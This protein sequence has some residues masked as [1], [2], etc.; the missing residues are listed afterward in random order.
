MI[1]IILEVLLEWGPEAFCAF[2]AGRGLR[3]MTIN[4]QNV[5]ISSV[6]GNVAGRDMVINKTEKIQRNSINVESIKTGPGSN[7]KI[8]GGDFYD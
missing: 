2:S 7:I 4:N 5:N 6:N 3:N 8:S 1:T